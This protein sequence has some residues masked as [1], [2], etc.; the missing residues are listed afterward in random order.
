MVI[1]YRILGIIHE[2]KVS[3][4]S[5]FGTVREKTFA[6]QPISGNLIARIYQET[7]TKEKFH[8]FIKNR[9]VPKYTAAGIYCSYTKKMDSCVRGYEIWT[10]IIGKYLN[11]K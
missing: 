4:M 1:K 2:R 3:R 5:S 7:F 10:P 11:C 8:E 9:S 6:I